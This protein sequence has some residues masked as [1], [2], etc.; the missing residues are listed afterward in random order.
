M[1]TL[2]SMVFNSPYHRIMD[3]VQLEEMLC[4]FTTSVT[5]TSSIGNEVVV[6]DSKFAGAN[7]SPSL[8]NHLALLYRTYADEDEGGVCFLF[9]YLMYNNK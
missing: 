9:L 2:T 8:T 1:N 7:L 3:F 4:K 5:T 6:Y